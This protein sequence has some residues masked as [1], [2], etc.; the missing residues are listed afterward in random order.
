[1]K[2]F[3]L[4]A[5]KAAA[6][7][8]IAFVLLCLWCASYYNVPVHYENPTGATEYV[9]QSHKTYRKGTEGFVFGRTNNEGMNAPEDYHEGDRVDILLMGSSHM[10]GMNVEQEENTASVLEQLF[11]G[12]KNCY[13]IGMSGHTLAYCLS[14]LQAALDCYQPQDYVVIETRTLDFSDGEMGRLAEGK[15]QSIPSYS[16][17]PIVLLQKLPY[18]RLMY[19]KYL[20]DIDLGAHKPHETVPVEGVD[21]AYLDQV[22]SK[23]LADAAESCREAGVQPMIL[24]HPTLYLSKDGSPY[25]STDPADLERMERCCRENGI[26]FVDMTDSYLQGVTDGHRLPYG[27]ANTKPGMGHMNSWG[28]RLFAQGIYR[29]IMEQEG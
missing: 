27:F 3:C 28:H 18:L 6:A 9:W 2:K 17:G 29:T 1:M 4:W 5:L 22:L 16:S 15:L 26:L 23:V 13:N 21:P 12:E 24:Y 20:D 11:E 8:M 7:G 14:N 10:E 19:T 25:V